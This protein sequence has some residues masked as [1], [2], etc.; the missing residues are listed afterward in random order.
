MNSAVRGVKQGIAGFV[1]LLTC[2]VVR[3]FELADVNLV[4]LELS[5]SLSQCKAC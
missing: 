2:G 1:E 3:A 5:V 4:G